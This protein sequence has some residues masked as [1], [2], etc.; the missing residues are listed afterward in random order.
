[1]TRL[2]ACALLVLAGCQPPHTSPSTPAGVGFPCVVT[3][4]LGR[5]VTIPHRPERI[6]SLSPAATETLFAV[7]AGPRVVAVTT[8]DNYPPE[9]KRL[10]TIGGFSPETISVEAILAQKPDLVVAGGRFQ[11]PVVRAIAKFGPA[12]IVLDP[13]TLAEVQEAITLVGRATGQETQAAAVVADFHRRLEAVRQRTATVHEDD[14]PRVLYVLWDDPFQTAGPGTF[15]GQMISAAG[16]VN[17]F[18]DA[19]Q[20]YPRVSDEVVLA[21]NPDLI[22]VPDHGAAGL[23]ERVSKRPGWQKLR[24]VQRGRIVTVP[25]DLVNRPGPRLIDALEA[26]EGVIRKGR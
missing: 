23:P 12:V 19:A 4:S 5:S 14:R 20:A 26:I 10:P 24:A 1:M 9:V 16:G 2:I 17:L 21:R 15:V 6:V 22:L 8:T 3:D 18:A 13:G 7:G 11:E 25:D